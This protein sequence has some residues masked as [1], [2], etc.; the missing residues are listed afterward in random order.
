MKTINTKLSKIKIN[1]RYLQIVNGNNGYLIQ[2][3]YIPEQIC[4]SRCATT[5]NL[6]DD[7]WLQANI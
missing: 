1:H 4:C 2:I 3:D 7:T 6:P 5:F